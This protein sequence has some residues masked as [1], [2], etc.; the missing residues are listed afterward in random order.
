MVIR[1]NLQVQ[2][3]NLHFRLYFG[4]EVGVISGIAHGKRPQF[5]VVFVVKECRHFVGYIGEAFL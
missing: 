1:Q 2:L 5:I 3:G 4:V